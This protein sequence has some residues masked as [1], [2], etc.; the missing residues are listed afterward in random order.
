[1]AVPCAFYG[2]DDCVKLANDFAEVILTRHG[3]AARILDRLC[4]ANAT[5]RSLLEPLHVRFLMYTGGW[6]GFHLH[7]R[8]A[9]PCSLSFSFLAV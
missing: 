7:S 1:M 5:F 4:I 8:P 6:G 9:S 3:A 2:Y